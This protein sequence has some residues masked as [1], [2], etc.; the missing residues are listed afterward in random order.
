LFPLYGLVVI[1]I[2][3]AERH[4]VFKG[5]IDAWQAVHTSPMHVGQGKQAMKS[6]GI[7]KLAAGAF[8]QPYINV[9]RMH[10]LIFFFAFAD[11][12]HID[13]F[14]VYAVVCLVY[15]FP[16]KALKSRTAAQAV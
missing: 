8:G 3:V 12:I 6:G 15:F 11:F 7:K 13:S 2:L 5:F 14:I 4:H 16:W 1:P 10:M 9:I